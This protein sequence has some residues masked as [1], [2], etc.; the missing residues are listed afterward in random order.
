MNR[1]FVVEN[2]QVSTDRMMKA[3]EKRFLHRG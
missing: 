3:D 1:V 2:V